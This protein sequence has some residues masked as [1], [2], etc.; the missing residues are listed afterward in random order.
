MTKFKK[1]NG[2]FLTFSILKSI[3]IHVCVCFIV[4]YLKIGKIKYPNYDSVVSRKE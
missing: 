3:V 4:K 1:K 2:F